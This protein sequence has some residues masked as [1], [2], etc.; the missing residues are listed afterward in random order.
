MTSTPSRPAAPLRHDVAVDRLADLGL[1][2]VAADDAGLEARSSPWPGALELRPRGLVDLLDHGGGEGRV[3]GGAG[4]EGEQDLGLDAL[5]LVVVFKAGARDR[6]RAVVVDEAAKAGGGA[7][8]RGLEA[9]VGGGRAELVVLPG[10]D[11]LL[12]LGE[13]LIAQVIEGAVDEEVRAEAVVDVAEVGAGLKDRYE[14][15]DVGVAGGLAAALDQDLDVAEDPE[16]GLE[17]AQ[18]LDDEVIVGKE[19]ARMSLSILR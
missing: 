12:E 18:V 13:L 19:R 6:A 9:G 2:D 11:V 4:G 16:A 1:A 7:R 17:R 10:L 15:L 5:T 3:G 8:V 14:G